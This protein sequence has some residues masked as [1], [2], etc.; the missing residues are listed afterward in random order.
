MMEKIK[1]I[2]K[3]K[4]GN[5][6]PLS[7][8]AIYIFSL[9]KSGSS[10]EVQW[11]RT[12]HCHCCS[13]GLIPGLGT[14]ACCRC[15]QKKKRKK[16]RKILF[17]L[18]LFLRLFFLDVMSLGLECRSVYTSL[19][20]LEFSGHVD[21]CLSS[22]QEPAKCILLKQ[23]FYPIIYILSF[24]FLYVSWTLLF[25]PSYLLSLFTVLF[26]FLDS[27]WLIFLML[28]CR[29]LKTSSL[30]LNLP[31]NPSIK[32]VRRET[33][34]FFCFKSFRRPGIEPVPQQRPKLL[35]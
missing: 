35:Q 12:R 8:G 30:E 25:Y 29:S 34:F 20:S 17:F 19:D 9:Q 23:C 10:L 13:L 11:L 5:L 2:K 27:F 6:I 18:Q 31:F 32:L 28:S 3:K 16:K 33:L 7:S 14:S 21:S 4:K 22:I 15:G 1:I 24:P 26:I